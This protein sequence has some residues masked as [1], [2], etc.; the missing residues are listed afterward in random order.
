MCGWKIAGGKTTAVGSGV[1]VSA[2]AGLVV[3]LGVTRKVTLGVIVGV[4]IDVAGKVVDIAG[5]VDDVFC[6]AVGAI[7]PILKGKILLLMT[8]N[9]PKPKRAI[10]NKI[11]GIRKSFLRFD[12]C[13]ALTGSI[14]LATLR[15]VG[16]GTATAAGMGGRGFSMGAGDRSSFVRDGF[17]STASGIAC[18]A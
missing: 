5:R 17:A 18:N 7:D 13:L 15:D 8:K 12:F 10:N 1:S 6:V 4:P 3:A 2:A 11:I 16:A 14:R 9:A